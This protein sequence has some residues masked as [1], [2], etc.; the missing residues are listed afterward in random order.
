MFAA[1]IEP[2]VIINDLTA[3]WSAIGAPEVAVIGRGT[4]IFIMEAM[5]MR[6]G[7]LWLMYQ[8]LIF[9]L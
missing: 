4:K 5:I 3:F 8:G 9:H 2:E 6:S 7:E 1:P